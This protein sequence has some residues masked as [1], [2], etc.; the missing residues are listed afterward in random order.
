VTDWKPKK[1]EGGRG[2][3]YWVLIPEL[4]GKHP[5]VADLRIEVPVEKGWLAQQERILGFA[6]EE[7]KRKVG[8]R[9]LLRGRPAFA[10][11]LNALHDAISELLDAPV[12]EDDNV[13]EKLLTAVEEVGLLLDSYLQPTRVQVIFLTSSDIDDGCRD[14]LQAWRDDL[15]VV[16][17]EAGITLHPHDVRALDA[18]PASEYRRMAIVWRR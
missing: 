2:P 1:L 16:L 8:E 5:Y 12:A 18:L 11:E 6:D 15:T 10:R 13:G 7:A 17:Q 3:R 9:L 4:E 14:R